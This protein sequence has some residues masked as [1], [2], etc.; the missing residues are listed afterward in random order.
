MIDT[1]GLMN[2]LQSYTQIFIDAN[3][4]DRVVTM[5][6]RL[7]RDRPTISRLLSNDDVYQFWYRFQELFT[8][9]KKRVWKALCNGIG[10]YLKELQKRDVLDTECEYLRR[11]NFELKHILRGY[12][13]K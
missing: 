7:K 8:D 12:E 5:V 13:N 2:A 6:D 3:Q 1:K 11:Q 10:V 9:D 4:L